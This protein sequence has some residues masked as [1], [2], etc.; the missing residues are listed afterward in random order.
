V[1]DLLSGEGALAV[2]PAPVSGTPTVLLAVDVS[3]EAKAR[4]I[5][6]RLAT[7][8]AASGNLHIQSTQIGSVDAK[9]ITLANGTS[10]FAAVFDG[11]LVTTNSRLAI[12]RMQGDGPKLADDSAY[13]A[14]VSGAD[15]PAETSGFVY[16]DLSEALE[17]AFDYAEN[18]GK[19]V[20]QVVKDNTA[21]LHGLLLYGSEDG[22]S[23]SLTGFV[24]IQ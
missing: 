21:P 13:T 12:Q 7:L 14:A 19:T 18:Q 6:D 3:D 1:F 2:Y 9:E 20:P 15:V 10:A 4:N 16:A 5:L 24:G 8:A 17:Y 22:G 23:F 11:R